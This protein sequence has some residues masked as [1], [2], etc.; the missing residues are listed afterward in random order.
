M[1]A[2]GFIA[3]SAFLALTTGNASAQTTEE[4]PPGAE[5]VIFDDVSGPYHLRVSQS[6]AR[7]IVGTVRIVVIP[8]DAATGEPVENALVRIFG[9]PPEHGERQ[10]SPGLNSPTDRTRYFGQMQLEEAGAWTIDVE[11]DADQGRAIAVSQATIHDRARSGTSTLVGTLMFI[12][13]S[14]AFVGSGFWLW[15]SSKRA[16]RRRDEIRRSGGTPRRSSG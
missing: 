1:L 5:L 13:I 15:Y 3:A 7:S 2:A 8:T 11:I 16:R 10:F 4:P 6:P 12:L 14:G 9:T